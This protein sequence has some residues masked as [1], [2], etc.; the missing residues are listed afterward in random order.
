M[1][2]SAATADKL[3]NKYTMKTGNRLQET[4]LSLVTGSPGGDLEVGESF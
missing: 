3:Y 2:V 4:Y 1:V